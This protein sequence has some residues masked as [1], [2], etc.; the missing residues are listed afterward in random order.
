MRNK[1]FLWNEILR[2]NDKKIRQLYTGHKI[3]T[4][5]EP[6]KENDRYFIFIIYAITV[7]LPTDERP[8]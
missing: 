7:Y 4:S 5:S 6:A 2:S 3:N 8:L 1:K